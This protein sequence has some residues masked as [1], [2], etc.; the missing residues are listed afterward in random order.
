[1]MG[2]KLSIRIKE[3]ELERLNLLCEKFKESPSQTIRRLL[4][5]DRVKEIEFTG[6]L[7][8]LKNRLEENDSQLQRLEELARFTA[9]LLSGLTRRSAKSDPGEAEKLIQAARRE[10][11][12]H[13]EGRAKPV[14]D[15]DK[16]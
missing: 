14:S 8:E 6:L 2:K 3:K 9:S 15:Q 16:N 10:V 11:V 13:R 1:M 12:A 5:E 4:A 7:N